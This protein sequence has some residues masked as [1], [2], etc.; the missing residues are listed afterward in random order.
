MNHLHPIV[1]GFLSA[2]EPLGVVLEKH[3]HSDQPL[4]SAFLSLSKEAPESNI[5]LSLIEQID[6]AIIEGPLIPIYIYFLYVWLFPT[7]IDTNKRKK[8]NP[9]C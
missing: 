6:K 2:K 8:L 5:N 7:T 1:E 3:C 9:Y 4:E